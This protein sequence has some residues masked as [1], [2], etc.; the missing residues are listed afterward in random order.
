MTR[1]VTASNS[2]MD[3][4]L[5]RSPE[6]LDPG[7]RPWP[8]ETPPA[9][10]RHLRSEARSFDDLL[11]IL[12]DGLTGKNRTLS[13]IAS[14]DVA[15][16]MDEGWK[17]HPAIVEAIRCC[18]M[19]QYGSGF[20]AGVVL[21]MSRHLRDFTIEYTR[22]DGEVLSDLYCMKEKSGPSTFSIHLGQDIWLL[23]TTKDMTLSVPMMPMSWQ[24]AMRGRPM[25]DIV[26]HPCIG[27]DDIA[28]RLSPS[29]EFIEIFGLA[30]RSLSSLEFTPRQAK[31]EG[32]GT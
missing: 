10:V 26:D 20:D 4:L 9:F 17:V 14:Q 11:S 7:C 15:E 21:A 32:K 25:K 18:N 8:D 6:Q 16:A 19:Q 5:F 3:I 2:D 29:G 12:T 27:E 1:Y 23:T 30:P 28:Q 31:N 22:D 24:T 13:A